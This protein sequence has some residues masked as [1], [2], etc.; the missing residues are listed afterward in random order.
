M[1]GRILQVCAVG[2][3]VDK[4]LSPLLKSI[5]DEGFELHIACADDGNIEKLRERGYIVHN[6][7]FERKISFVSN[8]KSIRQLYR[9]M[10]LNKY[11][12]VHTHTPVAS[13]LARIAA[14][15]AGIKNIIYTAHGYYFHEG[16]NK[17][18]YNFYYQV[19]KQFARYATDYLLLQS[20]ED[21][22]LSINKKF[23]K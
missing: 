1:K 8:L 20:K 4:L 3:S 21:Y 7:H 2:M 14:K 18:Q 11:D 9:L 12:I 19:E 13:I 22:Q 23:K 10:K 5:K 6:I 15:L 17:K 16:M